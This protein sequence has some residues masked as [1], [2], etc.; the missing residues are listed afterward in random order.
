MTRVLL[1][2][3]MFLSVGCSISYVPPT[4]PDPT[5]GYVPIEGSAGEAWDAVLD[6][7][8]DFGMTVDF[9]SA[10][11]RFA[12]TS[13]VL[14]RGAVARIPMSRRRIR[15]L[16]EALEEEGAHRWA[17]CGLLNDIEASGVADLHADFSIR[18]RE[19]RGSGIVK[20]VV[21]RM[22][23]LGTDGRE[24]RCVSTGRFEDEMIDLIEERVA[25]MFR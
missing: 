4:D 22:W 8:A 20:V 19:D 17:D 13:G 10:E 18:V 1:C 3:L 25:P 12:R 24:F 14:A 15:F 9:I 23:M 2:V 11:M 5:P 7:I 21:P 6:V 16:S